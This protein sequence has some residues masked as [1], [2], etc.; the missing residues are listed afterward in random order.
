MFSGSL[1]GQGIRA[2]KYSTHDAND[3]EMSPVA[4]GLEVMIDVPVVGPGGHKPRRYKTLHGRVGSRHPDHLIVHYDSDKGTDIPV[5]LQTTKCHYLSVDELQ[6][7]N[8]LAYTSFMA[9]PAERTLGQSS[10]LLIPCTLTLCMYF[11]ATF[12]FL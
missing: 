12:L 7:F 9:R 1:V 10:G 6:G 2:G 8:E 4:W 11:T 3:V 5:V